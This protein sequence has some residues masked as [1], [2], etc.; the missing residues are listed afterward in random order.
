[1]SESVKLRIGAP[2][3]GLPLA[4][5]QALAAGSMGAAIEAA[6]NFQV[7]LGADEDPIGRRKLALA[8]AQGVIGHLQASQQAFVVNVRDGGGSPIERTTRI[9]VW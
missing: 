2:T 1:M 3:P 4:P 7:P 6:M 9:D 8:I 5:G